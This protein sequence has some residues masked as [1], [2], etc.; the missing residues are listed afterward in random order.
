[1]VNIVGRYVTSK[2]SNISLCLICID[3]SNKAQQHCYLKNRRTHVVN[4]PRGQQ[5]EHGQNNQYFSRVYV[6]LYYNTRNDIFKFV[7]FIFDLTI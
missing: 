4:V 5:N 7:I 6:G 3:V 2:F 1:M